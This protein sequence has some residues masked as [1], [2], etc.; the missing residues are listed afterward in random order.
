MPNVVAY[1]RVV[2]RPVSTAWDLDC[3]SATCSGGGPPCWA[4]VHLPVRWSRPLQLLRWWRLPRWRVHLQ[5]VSMPGPRAGHKVTSK[6]SDLHKGLSCSSFKVRFS[7]CLDLL[8]GPGSLSSRCCLGHAGCEHHQ[9]P[10]AAPIWSPDD[11][12]ISRHCLQSS[13][14]QNC[15]RL[16]TKKHRP[17]PLSASSCPS[18]RCLHRPPVPGAHR[19]VLRAW[20][21]PVL[22]LIASCVQPSAAF[23]LPMPL[24]ASELGTQ[25][26]AWAPL[27]LVGGI[28][29]EP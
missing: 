10:A 5:H 2:L 12:T 7:H 14:L 3:S 20:Q 8:I 18:R 6:W 21:C 26:P 27:I 17:R 4:L 16:R 29:P 28:W 11:Q 13:G 23:L 15:P 19:E 9:L 24:G 22:P 25:P 1:G